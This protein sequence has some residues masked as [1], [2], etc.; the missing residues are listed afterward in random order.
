MQEFPNA[1]EF[2]KSELVILV[3]GGSASG[4]STVA[5]AIQ[6][7]VKDNGLDVLVVDEPV[8]GSPDM[9]VLENIKGR[10]VLIRTVNISRS[11]VETDWHIQGEDK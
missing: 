10:K 11:A 6:K 7:L 8:T 3:C 4:K 2:A 9:R 5:S 1:P